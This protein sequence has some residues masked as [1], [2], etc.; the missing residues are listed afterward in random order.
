MHGLWNSNTKR[1]GVAT[2]PLSLNIKVFSVF[3]IANYNLPN[4]Y[5]G[6]ITFNKFNGIFVGILK[7][8]P[9]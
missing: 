4:I 2:S 6:P 9:I 1:L 5:I 3:L 8:Q 7:I